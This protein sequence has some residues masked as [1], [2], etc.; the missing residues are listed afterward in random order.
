MIA[1]SKELSLKALPTPGR[2]NK[3]SNRANNYPVKLLQ[4]YYKSGFLIV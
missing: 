4:Y 2:D 1:V 3:S